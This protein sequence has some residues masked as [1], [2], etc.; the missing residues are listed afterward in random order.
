MSDRL[1]QF[2]TRLRVARE[3]SGRSLRQ[4]ADSTKLGVRTLEAL[5]K[6]DLSR[7]PPAI[8]RRAVVRAYAS[9][10]G[11]D[12]ESTLHE[13]LEIAP[14]DLPP[15]GSGAKVIVD[16]PTRP[17]RLLRALR[18]A[19]QIGSALLPFLAGARDLSF[20]A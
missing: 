19:L 11:L 4:M 20:R 2:D 17:S 10:V 7:L 5:E 14:D 15:P 9:E 12:P 6:G 18:V 13:F 3:T 1:S 16:P 8:F